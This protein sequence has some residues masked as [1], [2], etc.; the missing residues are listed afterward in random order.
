M[1]AQVSQKQFY[2]ALVGHLPR[3]VY[4]VTLSLHHKRG[5]REK[6]NTGSLVTFLV[7]KKKR[8]NYKKTLKNCQR[9]LT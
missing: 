6:S 1:K 7:T 2:G 9:Y 8:C 5:V 4:H 3:C